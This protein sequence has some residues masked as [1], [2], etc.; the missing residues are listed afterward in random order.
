[1]DK[2]LS[3]PQVRELMFPGEMT[4]EDKEIFVK[5]VYDGYTY[6]MGEKPIRKKLARAKVRKWFHEY[7]LSKEDAQKAVQALVEFTKNQPKVIT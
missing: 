4:W 3:Q 1:M 2:I 7:G 6:A 5:Y